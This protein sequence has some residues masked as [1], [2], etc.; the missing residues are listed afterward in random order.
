MTDYLGKYGNDVLYRMCVD[1]PNHTVPDDVYSKLWIIG[2]AY[3]VSLQRKAGIKNALKKAASVLIE[4]DVD[5][6]ISSVDCIDH[7]T[8]ENLHISLDAHARF[9]R[10][11]GKVAALDRRSLASKYLHFHRP[12]AFF[13]FDSVV[14]IH[15]RQRLRATEKACRRFK[16]QESWSE[17]DKEYA[18]YCLRAIYYRDNI[19]KCVNATPREIDKDLYPY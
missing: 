13:I 18:S 2:N 6:L 12:K 17:F 19:L 4:N 14:N 1:H 8:N 16:I 11:L 5:V 9:R 7:L 10:I 3:S 15:I